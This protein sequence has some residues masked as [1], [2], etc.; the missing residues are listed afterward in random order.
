MNKRGIL[1]DLNKLSE[2]A[3]PQSIKVMFHQRMRSQDESLN[4]DS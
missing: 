1:S 3:S 2:V 4:L